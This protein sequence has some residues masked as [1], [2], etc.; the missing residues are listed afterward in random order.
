MSPFREIALLPPQSPKS[1]RIAN[2][3]ISRGSGAQ[4][5][6]YRPMRVLPSQR[7]RGRTSSKH[8]SFKDTNTTR[9]LDAL[10]RTDL[11]DSPKQLN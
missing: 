4:R 5:P 10:D 1:R 6:D 11:A 3:Q 9:G 2:P 7:P 8:P